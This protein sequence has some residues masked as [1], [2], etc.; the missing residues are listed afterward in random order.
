VV[1][2]NNIDGHG[3]EL[4]YKVAWQQ[5]AIIDDIERQCLKSDAKYQIIDSKRV[6]TTTYL[7]QSYLVSLS[8]CGISL[9]GSKDLIPLRDKI[10]IIHYLSQAKGT[11]LSNKTISY[12]ELPEGANYFP[13][14]SKRAIK[15]VVE[16]FGKEPVRLVAVATK[17]GGYKADYGDI[18]VTINAFPR[19]PITFVL[20]Q[21]DD[22]FPP[23]GNILFDSNIADY[24]PIED[25]I[26]LCEAIAWKLVKSH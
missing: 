14:F 12:K 9:K 13:T 5:L 17:L 20:W 15:P 7:N 11:P 2:N 25:I 3:Y 21:G 24:L 26:V 23:E 4:A 22:E 8:D 18:A 10:L 1:L 16:H 19:I 6:I